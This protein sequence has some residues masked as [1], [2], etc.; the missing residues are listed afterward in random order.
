[1]IGSPR[2]GVPRRGKPFIGAPRGGVSTGG[3]VVLSHP[4]QRSLKFDDARNSQNVPLMMISRRDW[5]IDRLTQTVEDRFRFDR[6]AP[7]GVE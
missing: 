3:R 1:M 6:N 5:T 2:I 4:F 7:T